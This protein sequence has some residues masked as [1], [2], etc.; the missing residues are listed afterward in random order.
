M[1]ENIICCLRTAVTQVYRLLNME[2]ILYFA[3]NLFIAR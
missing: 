2:F 3:T 1:L